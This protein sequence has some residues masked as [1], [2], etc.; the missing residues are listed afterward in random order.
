[1]AKDGNVFFKWEKDQTKVLDFLQSPTYKL[2]AMQ[3][4]TVIQVYK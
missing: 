2:S 1:M 3:D 4:K